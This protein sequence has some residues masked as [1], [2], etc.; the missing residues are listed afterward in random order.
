M[1]PLLALLLLAASGCGQKASPVLP[2][3]PVKAVASL[4]PDPSIT[5]RLGGEYVQRGVII[6]GETGLWLAVPGEHVVL[7]FAPVPAVPADATCGRP[8]ADAG[9]WLFPGRHA[10][11]LELDTEATYWAYLP[12]RKCMVHWPALERP[13]GDEMQSVEVSWD[14]TPAEEGGEPEVDD[15][16]PSES[17]ELDLDGDGRAERVVLDLGGV[18]VYGTTPDDPKTEIDLGLLPEDGFDATIWNIGTLRLGFERGSSVLMHLTIEARSSSETSDSSVVD[19]VVGRLGPDQ[20]V[21]SLFREQSAPSKD[22]ED[23]G[24]T[25][26][27]ENGLRE[28]AWPVAHGML[29]GQSSWS[30]STRHVSDDPACRETLGLELPECSGDEDIYDASWSW[31]I[32]GDEQYVDLASGETNTT[33][34]LTCVDPSEQAE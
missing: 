9:I 2:T 14:Y 4:Q 33:K 19:E 31:T 25:S 27:Y 20:E 12:A 7:D 34:E 24:D 26:G 23:C 17:V 11:A 30:R 22:R 8:D 29:R 10:Y 16:A 6:D 32:D 13:S 1:R 28:I 21:Q 15:E 5:H 18:H 3:A